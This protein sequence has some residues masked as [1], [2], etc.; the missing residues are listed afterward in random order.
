MV[1]QLVI[2]FTNPLNILYITNNA[3]F[4]IH[5]IY[6]YIKYQK[7]KIPEWPPNLLE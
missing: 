5:S 6:P 3:S 4:I 2:V 7:T 1:T